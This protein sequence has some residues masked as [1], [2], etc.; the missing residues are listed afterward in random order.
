MFSGRKQMMRSQAS[1]DKL[2]PLLSHFVLQIVSDFICRRA[3]LPCQFWSKALA[4]FRH[5]RAGQH[6]HG[7]KVKE[8]VN[9]VS[10]ANKAKSSS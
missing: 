7:D 3:S 1:W 8:S 2:T 4:V 6:R 5:H 9:S 10:L